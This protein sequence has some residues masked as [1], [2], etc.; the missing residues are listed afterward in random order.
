M[1]Y[2]YELG[3]IP[4][5]QY[6]ALIEKKKMIET[7]V[8]A[9]KRKHPDEISSYPAEIRKQIEIEVKY[10]GYIQRQV[11]EAERFK[12]LEQV[13]IPSTIDFKNVKGLRREAQEKLDKIKPGS[14]GQASRIS[15]ISPCDISL[16][17][18]YIEATHKRKP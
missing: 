7:G 14:V 11:R 10:E 2:G 6:D 4:K 18:V 15:G 8:A 5:P 3:L 16:L 9:L 13:T 12:K 1:G 17:Y